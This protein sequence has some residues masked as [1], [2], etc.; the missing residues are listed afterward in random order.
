MKDSLKERIIGIFTIFNSI[1]SILIFEIFYCNVLFVRAVLNHTALTYNFSIFRII[2]YLAIIIAISLNIK[3]LSKYALENSKY[4]F[5]KYSLI[6]FIILLIG[7]LI[8]ICASRLIIQ[9]IAIF[10]ISAFMIGNFIMYIGT[11]IIKNMLIYGITFGMLFSITNQFNHALD[12]RVHFVSASN[13]S[14]GNFNFDK[15]VSDTNFQTWEQVLRY[16]NMPEGA[17][18]TH[19]GEKTYDVVEEAKPAKYNPIFYIPSAIGITIARLFKGTML[20]IYIAGRITN[21]ITYLLISAFVIKIIPFKKKIFAFILSIPMLIALAASYSI[22]ALCTATIGIFIAYVLRLFNQKEIHIK[23][24]IML[25]LTIA[26]LAV[27]KGMAYISVGLIVFILPFRKILKQNKKY[28]PYIVIALILIAI[29]GIVLLS[30]KVNIESD[31]RGG[32][33]NSSAQLQNIKENPIGLIKVFGKFSL[34]NLFD[35]GWMAQLNQAAFFGGFFQLAFMI[36]ILMSFYIAII[37]NEYNFKI[38]ERMIFILTYFITIYITSLALYIGFT[39]VG[40]DNINGYQG[41]YVLPILI[42]PFMSISTKNIKYLDSRNINLRI[43]LVLGMVTIL[44][45]IGMIVWVK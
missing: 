44:D 10:L 11:D 42:L 21:L 18:E 23:Q 43:S 30:Q 4:K 1:A 45:F 19:T 25:G 39:P 15:P 32:D 9:N 20:D 2:C 28:I 31:P 33:T 6:I 37:D 13:I 34:T 27:V 35:F 22:D 17:F 8:Y 40:A 16:N 12:E 14:Y 29:I 5:K 24:I 7:E 41:R 3:K 26:M 38:K 36:L